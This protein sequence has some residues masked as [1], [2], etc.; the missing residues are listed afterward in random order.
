MDNASIIN[1]NRFALFIAGLRLLGISV[2]EVADPCKSA[3]MRNLL[4]CYDL[5]TTQSIP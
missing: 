1:K 3:Y 4:F 2:V 5:S